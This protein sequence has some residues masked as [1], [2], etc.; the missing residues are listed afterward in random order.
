M[1]KRML[2][3][4]EMTSD[5]NEKYN[6]RTS[7]RLHGTKIPE[8][9]SVDNVMAVVN[10]CNEKINVPFDQDNTDRVHRIGKKY[11]DVNTEKKVQAIIVIF[12]SW[13]SCKEF[14]D[15]RPRKFDN[16]KKKPGLSFFYVYLYPTRRRYLLLQTAKGVI[17]DNPD[18]SYVYGEC[19]LVIKFKNGSFKYFN[20]FNELHSLL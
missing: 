8:N 13:K 3:L 16:G 9:E 10:Y 2:D 15:A 1:E 6:Q 7:I 11:T 14:C 19:S 20:S 4:L 17:K 12:K 18:I 5:N